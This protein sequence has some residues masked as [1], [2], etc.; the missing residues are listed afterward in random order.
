MR[1]RASSLIPHPSSLSW[2]DR[3]MSELE[4]APDLIS[5][6]AYEFAERWRRGE[7]P[8]LTEY[9]ARYPDLAVQIRELFP[10]LVMMEQFGSVA[11]KT[12]EANAASGTVP[13]QL[14]EHRLLAAI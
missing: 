8:A 4:S 10:A 1:R 13:R 2:G 12:P 3:T 5:N 6:L 14:G 7:R 11:G 9:T